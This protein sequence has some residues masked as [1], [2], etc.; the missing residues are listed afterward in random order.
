MMW[1]ISCRFLNATQGLCAAVGTFNDCITKHI[2]D[3]TYNCPKRCF[4]MSLPNKID[5]PDCQSWEEWTCMR[6]QIILVFEQIPDICPIECTMTY[7]EGRLVQQI[8]S[9]P[10]QYQFYF[11]IYHGT[12]IAEEYIITTFSDLI[13]SFG[14]TMGLF[15]GFSFL[16]L[17]YDVLDTIVE[18]IKATMKL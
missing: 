15:A 8:A 7:Y 4:P 13:G 3:Q 14:G 12:I 16:G 6:N 10:S 11:Q 5:L 9:L 18:F 17:L 2:L 1:N